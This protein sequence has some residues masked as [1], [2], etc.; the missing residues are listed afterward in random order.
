M[1]RTLLAVFSLLSSALLSS[2]FITLPSVS[3]RQQR[4]TCLDAAESHVANQPIYR[5]IKGQQPARYQVLHDAFIAA[6]NAG[7]SESQALEY[8]SQCW[9]N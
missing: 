2:A 5:T 4:Q 9:Q 7:S 3:P 6:V 8:L 1:Q